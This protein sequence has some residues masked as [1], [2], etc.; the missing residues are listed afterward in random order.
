MSE[1]DAGLCLARRREKRITSSRQIPT[2]WP[3]GGICAKTGVVSAVNRN[4]ST[5]PKRTNKWIYKKVILTACA[6]SPTH[7]TLPLHHLPDIPSEKTGNRNHS[8]TPSTISLT[9]CTLL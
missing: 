9:G 4:V 8:F 7:I 6:A 2:D 1:V 5:E 3:C